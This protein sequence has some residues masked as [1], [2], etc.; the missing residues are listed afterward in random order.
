MPTLLLASTPSARK[1]YYGNEALSGL[2]LLGEVRLNESEIPLT[3]GRFAALADGCEIVVSDRQSA[4]PAELFDALPQLTA[5]VRVAV[6]IRNIDVA[7]ASRNGVLVTRASPG[8][9]ASVA[10]L[11]IG[12]MVALAR[13][14]V[15][16]VIDYRAGR[17]PEIRMGRQL[18]GSTV[19][20]IGYGAIGKYL[21]DVA[22]ALGM[23]VIVSDPY[24]EQTPRYLTNVDLPSLLRSSD[25]VVCLA[26]ASDKTEKLMNAEAFGQMKP[27]SYFINAS[28]GDLV[29]DAA[30]EAALSDGHI[31]GAALDVG[32]AA[33]Q[34]PTAA[35]ARHPNVIATPHI[36]GL[37][38]P[39]I[40]HQALETVS[41]CAS[42]LA[43]QAPPGSVNPGDATRL[44][45][46]L[47]QHSRQREMNGD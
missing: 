38:P 3:T 46:R 5:F 34:M 7:A 24:V 41:Q 15:D 1:N 27:G 21:A 10:E 36:G 47:H 30:L 43:G 2:R 8:F 14:M 40:S 25:F 39:S 35:L 19:G 29:D 4:A 45:T 31:A 17:H 18:R 9:M 16:A 22:S 6:D 44:K 37:T 32:R 20:I 33:D 23:R 11:I 13:H 26:A 28:R 12:D 42:I